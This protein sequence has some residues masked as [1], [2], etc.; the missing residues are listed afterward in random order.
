[1]ADGRVAT[2]RLISVAAVSTR[3]QQGS[4]LAQRRLR[5]ADGIDQSGLAP[6]GRDTR[7]RA[8]SMFWSAKVS[9]CLAVST[10][11]AT[12]ASA[13]SANWL[14]SAASACADG[15][16]R[17]VRSTICWVIASSRLGALMTRSRSCANA[18]RWESSSRSALAAATTTRVSRSRRCA[19]VSGTASSRIWRTLKACASVVF[20][21][22]TA[23]LNGEVSLSPNSSTAKA[24]SLSL[25]RT[26]L[27]TSTTIDFDRS[28]SASI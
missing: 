11:P 3:I 12:E 28:S 13:V 9:R 19:I 17:A 22:T 10:L 6:A 20:A 16:S 7:S 27:S 25:V 4:R 23:W 21:L 14:C 26:A 15:S 5:R 18:S 2:A 1:M 24:N 8:V